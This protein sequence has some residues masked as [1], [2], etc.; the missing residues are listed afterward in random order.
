[1]DFHLALFLGLR[2][3]PVAKVWATDGGWDSLWV[4]LKVR[5]VYM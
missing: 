5:L 4:F 1:M 3:E 2:L